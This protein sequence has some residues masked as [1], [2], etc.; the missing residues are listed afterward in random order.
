MDL[1]KKV[2]FICRAGKHSRA[3][4]VLHSPIPDNPSG[5]QTQLDCGWEP[6]V[7]SGMSPHHFGGHFGL[8]DGKKGKSRMESN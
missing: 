1:K 5:S 4:M 3:G 6:T 7:K 8:Q 2:Q